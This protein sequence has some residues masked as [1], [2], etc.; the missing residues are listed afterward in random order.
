MRVNDE[1]SNPCIERNSSYIR[2]DTT[3]VL[4]MDR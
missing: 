1:M 2:V 4:G 3:T